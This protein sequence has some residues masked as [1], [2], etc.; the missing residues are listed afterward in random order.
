MEPLRASYRNNEKDYQAF[1]AFHTFRANWRRTFLMPMVAAGLA[2]AL[3]ACTFIFRFNM[4]TAALLC[5]IVAVLLPPAGYLAQRAKISKNIR[6]NADFRKT[7]N[8]YEFGDAFA[9]TV[10]KGSREERSELDY[11]AFFRGYET[12]N[13]IFL[14]V[15]GASAFIVPKG[16]IAG[17]AAALVD[18]LGQKLG[19]RFRA[20]R[21]RK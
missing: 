18:L 15:N 16:E 20:R 17:D 8:A 19:E 14:Y 7:S 1:G 12:K 2:A 10:K 4:I 13:Y 11:A 3:T 6:A 21:G 9:V 5:L